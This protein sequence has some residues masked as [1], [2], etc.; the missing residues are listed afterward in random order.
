MNLLSSAVSPQWTPDLIDRVPA[1]IPLRRIVR[2]LPTGA[3]PACEDFNAIAGAC[4][5]PLENAA[6]KPLRFV[7]QETRQATFEDKFEPRVTCA[8]KCRCARATGTIL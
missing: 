5:P 8:V 1:F 7:P 6:G 3:W 4:H 2:A